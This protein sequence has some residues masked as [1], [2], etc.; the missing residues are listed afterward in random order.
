LKQVKPLRQAVHQLDILRRFGRLRPDRFVLAG[1]TNSIFVD[2]REP[3]GRAILRNAG[4]GQPSSKAVWR[5]A[6]DSGQPDLVLDV[7]A[8]YGEFVFLPDYSPGTRVIGIEANPHLYE[9]LQRSLAIHPSRA[10]IELY[11]ALAARSDGDDTTFYLDGGWSGRSSA[12]LHDSLVQPTAIQVPTIS[13][14]SL[15]VDSPSP[16]T[17]LFKI[18]VE[19]YESEVL[20]GMTRL[21]AGA[22]AVLG[23]VECN[24]R[25][26]ADVGISLGDFLDQLRSIGDLYRITS[27]GG[28][29]AFEEHRT[30]D[31]GEDVVVVR[32]WA[33]EP[34][35][36]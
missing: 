11:C 21:L 33:A 35:G 3:R 5:W 22:S 14:D 6:L 29:S 36:V 18:D 28:L 17:V 32:G 30:A 4:G 23:I 27:N 13:V 34:P 26:L 9:H 12:V 31:S 20:A 1:S 7:G 10:Q 8:N 2:S 19:G 25:F 16:A 15:F 24:E